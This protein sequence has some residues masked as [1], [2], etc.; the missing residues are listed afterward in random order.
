MTFHTGK[1]VHIILRSVWVA[2]WPPFGKKLFTRLTI[3]SFCSLTFCNISYFPFGIEGWIWVLIAS[4]TDHT[5][6]F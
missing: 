6:Y 2:G 1:C 5:F 3:C 4:V